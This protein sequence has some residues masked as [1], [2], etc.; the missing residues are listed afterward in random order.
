MEEWGL[1]RKNNRLQW[2]KDETPPDTCRILSNVRCLSEGVDVPALDAVLFLTPRNS[3]VDVVQSVGR[4]MRKSGNKKLG[5]VILPVVIPANVTPEEALNDNKTYKVVWE[6]LQALRSHDDR[7]DAM[8]NKL[9][10]TGQ[11]RSKMEVIAVTNSVAPKTKTKKE[12]QKLGKNTD[13]LGKPTG[14]KEVGTG[15]DA[16]L[17]LTMEF[18]E[19][20]RAILAKV[21]KKVGNRLYWDDWAKDIAKIAQTHIS[22]ITAILGTESNTSEIKAFN[23]FL[24]E[25]RADLN[26]GITRAEA[27]EML[28]QHIIT[29]PV[30]DALFEGYSFTSNNP[31]SKAMQ[32]VLDVLNEHNLDKESETLTKFY[33]SVRMRASGIT[34]VKAKQKIIVD[35]YDK[36]FQERLPEVG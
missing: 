23:K 12:N 6:V 3:Q 30:F 18:S 32:G 11:D 9:E 8:I 31:V 20:E 7:F 19:I 22:R 16:Q 2:L 10:L 35:L 1:R 33:E 24:K 27:I 13:N 17:K 15:E 26:D 29:K 36:F 28:A 14:K 5:Y 34:E 4:V 21:V 25:L